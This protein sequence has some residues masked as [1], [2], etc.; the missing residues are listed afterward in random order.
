MSPDTEQQV[1]IAL[2][3]VHRQ[4]ETILRQMAE[5]KMEM[6]AKLSD[7][8]TGLAVHV[9]SC[10]ERHIGVDIARHADEN[11]L[12]KCEGS[13]E[14]LFDQSALAHRNE[15]KNL[16]RRVSQFEAQEHDELAHSVATVREHQTYWTRTAVSIAVSIGVGLMGLGGALVKVFF[17]K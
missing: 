9:A 14:T 4:G 12:I 17:L 8:T 10:K 6:H 2:A 3:E 7:L 13:I 16:E 1:V 5:N 15:R 11:R